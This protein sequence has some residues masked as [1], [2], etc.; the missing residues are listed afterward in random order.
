MT[1]DEHDGLTDEELEGA[2]GEQLPDREEMSPVPLPDPIG[3]GGFTLPV[4]PPASE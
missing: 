2:N 1:N 3:G 4:E